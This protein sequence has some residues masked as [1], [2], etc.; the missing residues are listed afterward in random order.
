MTFYGQRN[1]LWAS[2]TLGN[3][4]RTIAQVGCTTC[5]IS[6]AA[7]YF[8]IFFLKSLGENFSNVE[9]TPEILA[10][11]LEYTPDARILWESVHRKLGISTNRFY[12]HRKDVIASALDPKN[13]NQCVALNV[14]NGGHW[15][16]ALR[17]LPFNRYWVH[18]PWYDRK[19]IYSG[20]VGGA[21]FKN[22][23]IDKISLIISN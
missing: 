17:A 12:G 1:P 2:V 4:K 16:F 8:R 15:V 11:K 22:C 14:D 20:V 21:V 9:P 10:K 23:Y 3:T 19:R 6:D 13:T 5:C 7:S 18:D